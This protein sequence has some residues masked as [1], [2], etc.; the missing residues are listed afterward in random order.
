MKT[1]M[2]FILPLLAGTLAAAPSELQR[3]IDAGIRRNI[4][5]TGLCS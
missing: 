1:L 5:L 4:V 3:E 2:A